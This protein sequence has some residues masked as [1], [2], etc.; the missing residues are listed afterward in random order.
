MRATKEEKAKAFDLLLEY[1]IQTRNATVGWWSAIPRAIH[2]DQICRMNTYLKAVQTEHWMIEDE[3]NLVMFYDAWD[4]W[5]KKN[6]KESSDSN[7][8]STT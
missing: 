5:G 2:H 3:E 4:A 1:H 8:T 7:I 6:E